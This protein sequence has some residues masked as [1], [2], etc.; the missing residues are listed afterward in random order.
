LNNGAVSDI[1]NII[2]SSVAF[3]AL[4]K[5]KDHLE[6]DIMDISEQLKST[7]FASIRPTYVERYAYNIYNMFRQSIVKLGEQLKESEAA[8][9]RLREEIKDIKQRQQELMNN[10]RP[11]V[12]R[13]PS[14]VEKVQFVN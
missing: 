14:V 10:K 9:E 11:P 4:L 12:P 3:E 6:D 2:H 5:D 8:N 7:Q 13:S 1:D